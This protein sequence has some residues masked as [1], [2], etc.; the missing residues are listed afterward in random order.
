MEAAILLDDEQFE[1]MQNA[2]LSSMQI[3]SDVRE[4]ADSWTIKNFEGDQ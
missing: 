4:R 1:D 3:V 2:M